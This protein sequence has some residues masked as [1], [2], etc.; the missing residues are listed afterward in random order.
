VLLSGDHA[1]IESW[2]RERSLELTQQRRPD[3]LQPVVGSSPSAT[4]PATTVVLRDADAT[5]YDAIDALLRASFPTPAEA[6]LVRELRAAGD[7]PIAVVAEVDGQVVG[8]ALLS[9]VTVD[10]GDGRFRGLGLA[11]VAVS[12]TCRGM[13]IGKALVRQALRGA[14][15]AAVTGVVVL[16]EPGYYCPLGFDTASKFGLGNSFGVDEPFMYHPIKVQPIAPGTVR[17]ARAFEGLT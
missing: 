14:R 2:R 11:P 16:G 10:G 7:A 8:M 5:D 12:E 3:L 13:G 17:F 1:K 4:G 6:G 9:P 15:D